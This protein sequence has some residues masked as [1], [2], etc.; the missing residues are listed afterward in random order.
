MYAF[1]DIETGGFS[2]SKNGVCEIAVIITDQKFKI[3]S[4]VSRLI[5]PYTRPDS[6]ELV[7]YKEDAMKVNGI[8]VQDLHDKGL[9]I[10]FALQDIMYRLKSNNVKAIIGHNS[11][12]FDIPRINHLLD[13]FMNCNL[14]GYLLHDTMKI[15]KEKFKLDSYSLENCCKNFGIINSK[16]HSARGDARATLELFAKIQR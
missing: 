16:A 12:V 5:K 9:D 1:I 13:R 2:I 3:L 4:E 7:S 6:D 10:A 8:L 11:D 14:A 15:A